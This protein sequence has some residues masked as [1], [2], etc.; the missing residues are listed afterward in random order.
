M[1]DIKQLQEII[2]DTIKNITTS[3]IDK[4]SFLTLINGKISYKDDFNN[5]YKFT[6]E[7]EE[8]TAFSITGE[9]YEIDDLVFV[10]KMNNNP[11][12]KQMIL[13]KVND[14]TNFDLKLALNETI[15]DINNSLSDLEQKS[16]EI[17]IIGNT[18]FTLNDDLTITPESLTF[19][20]QRNENVGDIN[21][22]LDNNLLEKDKL[23]KATIL[24]EYMENRESATLRVTDINNIDTYDEVTIVRVMK[25]DTKLDLDLGL[26]SV[27]LQKEPNGIINYENAIIEPKVYSDGVD[28]TSNGW[29]IQYKI[30]N[31]NI[32]VSEDGK[33]YR[34]MEINSPQAKLSFYAYKNGNLYLQRTIYVIVVSKGGYYLD[35]ILN[36]SSFPI[37]TDNYG[38][39]SGNQII[40]NIKALRGIDTIRVSRSDKIPLLE[41][42]TPKITEKEDL[43][44][45]YVWDIPKGNSLNNKNN[46]Y[47]DVD[48]IVENNEQTKTFLWSKLKDGTPAVN[49]TIETIPKNIMLSK[50]KE[51]VPNQIVISSFVQHGEE[52][53]KPQPNIIKIYE[54]Y[55]N[56][57]Y[58]LKYTSEEKETT[59]TYLIETPEIKNLKIVLNNGDI[60]L[61]NEYVNITL[62]SDEVQ[63]DIE[64]ITEKTV[65]YDTKF[66][67]VT[68]EIQALVKENETITT[69][70][71]DIE[72]VKIVEI[73]KKYAD[74]TINVDGISQ[75]VEKSATDITEINGELTS[76]NTRL[77][78]A[79]NKLTADQWNLWFTEV[80][81][82]KTA[83]STKF[84]MDK[85]GLHIKGGGIDISN[86]A[87]VKV[88]LADANGNLIINNLKAN[89]GEFIGS[90]SASSGKIGEMNINSSGFNFNG[91]R[92]IREP[93]YTGT[94]KINFDF[95][96]PGGSNDY[97][98]RIGYSDSAGQADEFALIVTPFRIG[99][100]VWAG[101]ME[102]YTIACSDFQN[103]SDER[104]KENFHKMNLSKII[105]D[106][107]VMSYN[108]KTT[109]KKE[110]IGILAQRYIEKDYGKFLVNYDKER[111]LY[112]IKTNTILFAAVQKIQELNLRILELEKINENKV[113]I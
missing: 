109:P 66:T 40:F 94:H 102:A 58:I 80:V 33:K 107:D 84:S 113:N 64:K 45:E 54:T 103:V 86:N 18:I 5:F 30:D 11:E 71:K 110:E 92:Y 74:L 46:G 104:Y 19:A 28:V 93:G 23:K 25:S 97:A 69:T 100:G 89:N 57:D 81:N 21:W 67:T 14:Y 105:D 48:F 73:N 42:L 62:D 112:S 10:L 87:G 36:N 61:T 17:A 85:N 26:D 16:K 76:Q 9:E 101:R 98:M 53:K 7:K 47:V 75:K 68:G 1:D 88:L 52:N 27:L 35:I 82:G 70:I 39:T 79:E 4:T 43:S 34:I 38:I 6:Y 31:G 51:Y 55:N 37:P 2:V 59:H 20:A 111:D 44:L 99:W 41:G 106:L 3:Y 95:K 49:Y 90:I 8:Y 96:V 15:E 56:I 13:S 60:D 24:N 29:T 65:E 22:Y 78:S 77:N 91:L 83:V 72:E 50:T 32:K 12:T 63:D 108:F